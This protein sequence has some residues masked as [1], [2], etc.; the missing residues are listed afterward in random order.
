[1]LEWFN[2]VVWRLEQLRT[3]SMKVGLTPKAIGLNKDAIRT[4]L[5]VYRN[6][7]AGLVQKRI[8]FQQKDFSDLELLVKRPVQDEL[9]S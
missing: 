5:M 8:I 9:E 6:L 2:L 1:M 4:N 3:E 7:K